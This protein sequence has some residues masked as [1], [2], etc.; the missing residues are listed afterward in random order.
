MNDTIELIDWLQIENDEQIKLK[1]NTDLVVNSTIDN[2]ESI[3]ES[4][5]E[6]ELNISPLE[7]IQLK[8]GTIIPKKQ[9]DSDQINQYRYDTYKYFKWVYG[10]EWI[11]NF[12]ILVNS[13]KSLSQI[14]NFTLDIKDIDILEKIYW[15]FII[16]LELI[17]KSN[18]SKWIINILQ[19]NDISLEL[20]KILWV[21][22]YYEWNK[23]LSYMFLS[24][25]HKT[26]YLC[27]DK[28]LLSVYID[29]NKDF[30]H[31]KWIEIYINFYFD[32][33]ID[34]HEKNKLDINY[35][36]EKFINE[37]LFVYENYIDYY[38][39]VESDSKKIIWLSIKSIELWNTN[40]NFH[41]IYWYLLEKDYESASNLYNQWKWSDDEQL[42]TFTNK[43][44]IEEFYIFWT[45]FEI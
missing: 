25:L 38:T 10:D 44:E 8:S 21:F 12:F 7:S 19:N 16:E 37:L 35:D 24:E 23:D 18:I 1:K 9:S 41:L 13:S 17:W 42:V 33:V 30:N 22:F 43:S 45:E 4:N 31:V 15:L 5:N 34:N 40:S 3:I 26:S 11:N 39:L 14:D 29:L 28:E 6:Y 32:I 20:N 27:Q 36:N 2:F